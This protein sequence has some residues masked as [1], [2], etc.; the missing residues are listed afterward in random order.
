MM[1]Y[2]L[3]AIAALLFAPAA[4]AAPLVSNVYVRAD[5][6]MVMDAHAGDS[7]LANN[8]SFGAGV[9]A[10]VG[11]L[12]MD[13]SANQHEADLGPVVGRARD[14][15]GNAYFDIPLSQA[16]AVFVGGGVDY[17]DVNASYAGY[18]RSAH[19]WGWNVAGGA[20]HRFSEHV[21]GQVQVTRIQ[22]NDV[23]F[24]CGDIKLKGYT[25]Q[26]GLRINL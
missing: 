13:I 23:D 24:G 17:L 15:R 12:R 20:S 14:Y 25:A 11:P 9:G 7:L 4:F 10:Q 1:K 8:A 3:A 6:G 5:A 16:D 18:N 22:A 19:S 26:V 21:V 2:A